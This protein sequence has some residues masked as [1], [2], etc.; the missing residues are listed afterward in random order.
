MVRFKNRWLLVEFI[1]LHEATNN[2]LNGQ[3]IFN[4]LKQSIV[5]NFGDTGWGAVGMSLN[6]ARDHH[7]L[8]WAAL[9]LV[10]AV[11]TSRYIPNVVH[12]SGTIKHAQLAAVE[13][14]RKAIA[15]YRALAKTPAAYH[16]SYE[17]YLETSSKE[18]E[19]L[20]G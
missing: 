6:V 20:K 11:G 18:I 5:A 10:T 14:N 4:A 17:E 9:T 15:R 13:H 16:D 7:N 3:Q 12:L 19:S 2:T 8:A 1:P